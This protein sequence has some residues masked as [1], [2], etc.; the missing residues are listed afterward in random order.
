M[1]VKQT[2][3]VLEKGTWI[4][5]AVIGLSCIMSTMFIRVAVISA[6]KRR[7]KNHS[8]LQIFPQKNLNRIELI[9]DP[10]VCVGVFY[11]L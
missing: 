9:V 7:L 4:F 6:R 1:G 10:N 8:L 2:N 11:L 5:A 3:D